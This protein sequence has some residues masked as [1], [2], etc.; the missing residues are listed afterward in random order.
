MLITAGRLCGSSFINE[1][2]EKKLMQKLA[3]E[4]YLIKNG[5]TLK[6][7]AQSRTSVFEGYQKK[8]YDISNQK[9][10]LASIPIDD[11]RENPKKHFYENRMEFKR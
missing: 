10:P 6:S 3:K 4:T 11:L 7:I 8:I 9:A 5:K 1:R 2:F